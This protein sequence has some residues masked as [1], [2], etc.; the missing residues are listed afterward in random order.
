MKHTFN[1]RELDVLKI[2]LNSSEPMTG[3]DIVNAKCGNDYLTQST[4][5]A[6]LRKLLN[7]EYIEVAGVTHSGKV[8]S[9]T[10]VVTDVARTAIVEYIAEMYR[11]FV[12]ILGIYSLIMAILSSFDEDTKKNLLMEI[13]KL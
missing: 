12:P 6:V 11:P 7:A 5:T 8:L 1:P 10:Y 4:V 2:L 3:T 13:K 9:R